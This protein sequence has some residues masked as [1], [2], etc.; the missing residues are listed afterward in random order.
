MDDTGMVAMKLRKNNCVVAVLRK[1]LLCN[2]KSKQAQATEAEGEKHS[3]LISSASVMYARMRVR[4]I[5]F[6]NLKLNVAPVIVSTSSLTIL[7]I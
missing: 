7:S 2:R 4:S 5:L 1:D 6:V 3:D